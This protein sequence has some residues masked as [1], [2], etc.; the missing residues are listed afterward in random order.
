MGHLNKDS[1]GHLWKNSDGHLVVGCIGCNSCDP[2]LKRSYTVTLSGSITVE[3]CNNHDNTWSGSYTVEWHSGCE[4][5]YNATSGNPYVTLD[6]LGGSIGWRVLFS[7]HFGEDCHA[8]W[9]VDSADS[10]D[11]TGTYSWDNTNSGGGCDS[12]TTDST[13]EG[14]TVTVS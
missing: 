10:C 5:R 9:Y 7:P 11:P 13:T 14:R 2:P 4:W 1:N 12:C 8:D 6:W 3:G